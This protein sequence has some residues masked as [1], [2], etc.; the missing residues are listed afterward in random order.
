MQ[1]DQIATEFFFRKY[2]FGGNFLIYAG[3]NDVLDY[4]Q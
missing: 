4:L 1:N 3:L 2:P